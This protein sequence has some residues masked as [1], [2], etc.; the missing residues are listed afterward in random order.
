MKELSI[1]WLWFKDLPISDWDFYQQLKQVGV[2]I[3]PGSIFF[4]GLRDDWQ[5]RNQCLRI[6]LTGSDEEIDSAMGRLAKVVSEV[7]TNTHLR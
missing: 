5:H 6:S 4:P 1:S 2:I 3:V 7:Y